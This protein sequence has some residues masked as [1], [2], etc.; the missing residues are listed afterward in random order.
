MFLLALVTHIAFT[1]FFHNEQYSVISFY[2]IL[3]CAMEMDNH[4]KRSK[5]RPKTTW[6]RSIMAEL[7]D[8][9]LI[10]GEVQVIAQDRKRWRNNIVA[11]IPHGDDEDKQVIPI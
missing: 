3:Q 1:N 7:S 10:M 8:M 9:G 4:R 5:G 6:R 2:S 11:Y